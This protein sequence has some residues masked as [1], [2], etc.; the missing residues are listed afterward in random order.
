MKTVL[1][2]SLLALIVGLA[3]FGPIAAVVALTPSHSVLAAIACFLFSLVW[4]L[5]F[6]GKVAEPLVTR[7]FA[8][9]GGAK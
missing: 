1:K 4:G 5:F 3:W 9:T 6:C 7:V 8:M 2:L